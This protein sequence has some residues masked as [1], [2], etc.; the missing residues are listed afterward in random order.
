MTR[1]NN[2]KPKDVKRRALEQAKRLLAQ[3]VEPA[4]DPAKDEGPRNYIAS[5][6]REIPAVDALNDER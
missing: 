4:L 5:R 1:S 6:S 3:H 2:G